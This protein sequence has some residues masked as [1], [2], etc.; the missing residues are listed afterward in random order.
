MPKNVL[1][2]CTGNICRSPMAQALLQK[3]IAERGLDGDIVVDSAGTYA[4]AGYPASEG[5]VN[6]MQARGLDISQHRAKQLTADLVDQADLI[7]VM[8]EHHRRSIFVT[9]PKAIIKTLL[10]SELA[11]ESA[12]I[13]DPYGGA[14]WEYDAAADIIEDYVTRGMPALL[15]RLKVG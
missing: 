10:L 4:M 13:D 3:A 11:G 14:Q 7:L 9:W 12:G 2:V 6:A 8:E 1:V 5:S 15:Q